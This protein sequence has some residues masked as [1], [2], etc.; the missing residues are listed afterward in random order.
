MNIYDMPVHPAADIFPMLPDDELE[1]LAADIK[2]NGL[3][4]P[5][6][7]KDGQ[8]VDG[9]N[10]REA[11]RRAGVEPTVEELNGVDPAS[12]ILSANV[13]RRNLNKGQR[14]MAVAKLFPEPAT[15]KRKG[16]AGSIKNIEFLSRQYIGQARTVLRVLPEAADLVLAGTKSLND[17]YREA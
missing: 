6:A 17:A 12:Y 1:D 14:A 2:A 4:H 13:A 8:L 3:L 9:R 16:S 10:R 5:L 11:C 7:V 15:L